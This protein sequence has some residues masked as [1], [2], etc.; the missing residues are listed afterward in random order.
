MNNH[1]VTRRL[2]LR[3]KLL[4]SLISAGRG[5]IVHSISRRAIKAR[6]R[7]TIRPARRAS[8]AA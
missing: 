8:A 1:V 5:S 6:S 3:K 4:A 2:R 7:R